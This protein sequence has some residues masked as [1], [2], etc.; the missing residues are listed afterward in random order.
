MASLDNSD[1]KLVADGEKYLYGNGVPENCDRAQKNLQAAAQHSNSKA[2]TMLGAMY[3][4]GHCAARDLPTAYR[5]FARALRG[6]PG[7]NR[8]QRDLEILW[9]AMTPDERQLAM[10]RE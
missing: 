9:K 8:L 1:E 7:N 2:Q 3:A 5:F 10:R 6:D 4:T